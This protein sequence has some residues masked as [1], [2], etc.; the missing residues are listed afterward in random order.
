MGLFDLVEQQDGVGVLAS[1]DK[2]AAC[3]SGLPEA[4][5]ALIGVTGCET[6]DSE[7]ALSE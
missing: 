4:L 7:Q 3:E 1:E 6:G 5:L 2:A